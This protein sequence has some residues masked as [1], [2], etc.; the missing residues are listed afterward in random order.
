MNADYIN[1]CLRADEIRRAWKPKGGDRVLTKWN[2]SDNEIELTYLPKGI[3][4]KS[5]SKL[6]HKQ[7]DVW[8]PYQ[9]DLQTLLLTHYGSNYC[10]SNISHFLR[11][12]IEDMNVDRHTTKSELME[13]SNLVNHDLNTAWLSFAMEKMYNKRWNTTKSEWQPIEAKP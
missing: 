9:E 11:M 6:L 13:L 7:T 4:N 5:A 3:E 1:M 12:Y 10:I 2:S 8:L